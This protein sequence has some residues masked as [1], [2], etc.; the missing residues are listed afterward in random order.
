MHQ[1]TLYLLRHGE[2]ST[3]GILAGKTDVALSEKGQ[4]Q[5]WQATEQLPDITTCISSPLQRCQK[6]AS[7]FSHQHDIQLKIS[8]NLQEMNFGDWDGKQ[9]KKLWEITQNETQ[10][11][12]GDFWQNP[13][14][15]TPPNGEPMD[16]FVRR[17]DLWWQDWLADS[18]K[19]NTLVVAHGGVIKHLIARVLNMPIPGTAHMSHID[20]PYASVV[21]I[22]IYTDEQGKHWP[23]MVL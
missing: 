18:A 12:I 10:T 7:E 4:Q 1:R 6:F 17:V 15:F 11:A 14:K 8:K 3:P 20:V 13:W 16:D 22:T 2:I 21:K 9:Y 19:G 23:K 5:L